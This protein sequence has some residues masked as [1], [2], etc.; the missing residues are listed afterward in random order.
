MWSLNPFSIFVYAY[1][2]DALYVFRR[3]AGKV[4]GTGHA[5]GGRG[6][7][8]TPGHAAARSDCPVSGQGQPAGP[9]RPAL[10]AN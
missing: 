10:S 7:H 1:R 4:H 3:W 9:L 2:V 8:A 5:H 6:A